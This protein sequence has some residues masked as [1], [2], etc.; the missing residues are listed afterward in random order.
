MD[1]LGDSVHFDQRNQ[2]NSLIGL[3]N[4]DGSGNTV[5]ARRVPFANEGLK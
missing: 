2:T 1:R 4:S 5:G 3:N